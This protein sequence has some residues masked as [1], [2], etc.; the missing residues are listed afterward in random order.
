MGGVVEEILVIS[1]DLNQK[2]KAMFL[3]VTQSWSSHIKRSNKKD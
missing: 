3:S 2:I 1:S